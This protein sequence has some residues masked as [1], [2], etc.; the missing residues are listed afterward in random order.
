MTGTGVQ[1]LRAGLLGVFFALMTVLPVQAN[2]RVTEAEQLVSS[3][4]TELE[5]NAADNTATEEQNKQFL[6]RLVDTYFDVDGITRFSVG[7]Y[8]RVATKDEREDYAR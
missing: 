3:L 5:A 1:M 4:I 8:W 6:N 7:R 2:D